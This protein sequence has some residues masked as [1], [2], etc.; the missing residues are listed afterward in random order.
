MRDDGTVQLAEFPF[1][2][3][4]TDAYRSLLYF[5]QE[6]VRPPTPPVTQCWTGPAGIEHY[7]VADHPGRLIQSLKSFLAMRS[8]ESTQVFEKRRTVEELIGR[9]LTDVRVEA[10][11]QFGMDIRSATVG[12]PV[13]FVSADSEEDDRH[14]ERRLAL[15]FQLGG[16]D[17]IRFEMEPVAAAHTSTEARVRS[18]ARVMRLGPCVDPTARHRCAPV[19][20]PQR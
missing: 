14:A 16:F 7:L 3:K 15:A 5:E 17:D 13:R 2:G 8:M 19:P 18:D 10:S 11:R 20:S 12:R 9:I 4:I 6:P 1:L